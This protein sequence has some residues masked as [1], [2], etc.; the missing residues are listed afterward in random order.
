VTGLPAQIS[1]RLGGLILLAALVLVGCGTP[2]IASNPAAPLASATGGGTVESTPSTSLPSSPGSTAPPPAAASPSATAPASTLLPTLVPPSSNG[3]GWKPRG[4]T[5][6]GA[7]A[8]AVAVT[9]HGHIGLMWMNPELLR[10]RYIPGTRYP[11]RGPR[12]AQDRKPSTWVPRLV[13]AFN[14]AFHLKDNAG[15]YYYNGTQV[16]PMRVGLADFTVDRSGTLSVGV[17]TSKSRIDP[18]TRVIRQNLVP[19]VSQGSSRASVHDNRAKWGLANAGLPHANRTALGERSDGTLVFAYGSEITPDALAK[20]LV[21]AGVRTAVTLDMNKS[22]PTGFYYDAPKGSRA[23]VGHRIQPQIW[24]DPSTYYTE[25]TKDF[26]VG[27][28]R[29]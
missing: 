21:Q 3:L 24:R 10:F 7:H 23:P 9:D 25:F 26:V 27:L 19:L 12:R 2:G 18:K 16:T 6:R 14:G 11:E 8:V 29:Q 17:W 15:G 20:A 22:W 28:A 5:V 13:T 1:S 4:R